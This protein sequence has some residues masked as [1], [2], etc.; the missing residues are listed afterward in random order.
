VGG[1]LIAVGFACG[2]RAEQKAAVASPA[3][4]V[5]YTKL[6]TLS[7]TQVAGTF[8]LKANPKIAVRPPGTNLTW[9]LDHPAGYYIEIEFAAV[10]GAAGPFPKDA[11]IKENTAPGRYSNKATAA[12][13]IATANSK[14]GNDDTFWKY[15]VVLRDTN[16]NN[17][18]T[19]DPIVIFK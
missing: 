6:V 18:A 3:T 1:F 15:T 14:P 16:D 4:G 8:T 2:S 10:N 12:K 9:N 7:A 19:L 11:A 17:L 5:A 13:T